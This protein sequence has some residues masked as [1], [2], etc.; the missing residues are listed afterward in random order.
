MILVYQVKN[1]FFDWQCLTVQDDQVGVEVS[2]YGTLLRHLVPSVPNVC[3]QTHDFTLGGLAVTSF[4]TSLD[5][6]AELN[7]SRGGTFSQKY[8]SRLL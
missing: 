7:Q 1:Y 4:N 8:K 2:E 3:Q 5:S 6:P